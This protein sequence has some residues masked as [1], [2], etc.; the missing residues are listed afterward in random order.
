[1]PR[2]N[3]GHWLSPLAYML[4]ITIQELEAAI[5][6]WRSQSPAKGEELIL[7]KE[8]AALAKPYALMIVQ[9][10]QRMPIDI[11]DEACKEALTKFMGARNSS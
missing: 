6:Y 2:H 7:S 8:A 11:L 4:F 5:N 10:S 9:G 1:M 3:A